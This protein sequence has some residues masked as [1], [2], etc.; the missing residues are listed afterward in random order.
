MAKKISLQDL[1][2][3]LEDW[4]NQIRA[5]QREVD[6]I[7]TIYVSAHQ[8]SKAR[9]DQ[10]LNELSFWAAG[11]LDELPEQVRRAAENAVPAESETLERRRQELRSKLVPD[12]QQAADQMIQQSQAE[13]AKLRL[14]NPRLND[15]EESLKAKR[16][17]M[18]KELETLNQ[19][20]ARRSGCLRSIFNFSKL[21]DLDR[22]RE[23]LLGRLEGNAASLRQVREEWEKA[24]KEHAQME[25]DLQ[26]RWQ[27]ISLQIAALREE[28]DNLEND[29]RRG[30]LALQRAMRKTLDD[31]KAPTEAGSAPLAERVN[32]MAQ[33][34]IETDAFEVGLGKVAGLIALLG[35]IGSGLTGFR[36]SVQALIDEQSTHSAYLS[37]VSVLL[38]DEA[39]FFHSHWHELQERVRNEQA[40]G[41]NPL[42]FSAL[43]DAE[44]AGWLSK[45]GITRM[46]DS[47]ASELNA[48]TQSW[49]S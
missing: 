10:T 13:V 5:V 29:R 26:Q 6:E 14:M 7:Q 22:Q 25:S 30:D 44:I 31:W 43:F 27:A 45:A 38:S 18:E 47:L 35:G 42:E 17:Q 24:Y 11:H 2:Q 4:G 33:Y 23:K 41:K 16:L 21:N 46:F 20:I 15:L 8:E 32:Q 37:P 9:H 36:Q 49:R 39:T 12:L 19:E 1:D 40:L 3:R 28:L 34:N 48:A